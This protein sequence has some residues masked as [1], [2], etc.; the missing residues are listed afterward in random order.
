MKKLLLLTLGLLLSPAIS[1]AATT[2]LVN[3]VRISTGTLARQSGT[4]VVSAVDTSSITVQSTSTLKGA[5]LLAGLSAGTSGQVMTS[6]GPGL[7]PFWVA[8][9]SSGRILQVVRY[10]VSTTSSTTA[11]AWIN[12]FVQPQITPLSTGST[13]YI[14]ASVHCDVHNNATATI[15]LNV[16]WSRGGY[17]GTVLNTYGQFAAQGSGTSVAN[18]TWR[19]QPTFDWDSPG[20]LSLQTYVLQF[21]AAGSGAGTVYINESSFATALTSVILIEVGP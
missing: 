1:K 3:N 11:V 20:S 6:A 10:S 8:A 16:R 14:L 15:A 13:I 7:A 12:S 2:A 19:Q 17:G 21:N 4:E 18:D 9:G 5:V